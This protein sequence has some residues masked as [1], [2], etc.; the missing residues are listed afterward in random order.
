MEIEELQKAWEHMSHE[1]EHQK[2]LTDE[3]IMKMTKD[4]F[5]SKFRKLAT[6]ESIGAAICYG[7]SVLVLFNF[8]KLDTWYLMV[9]GIVTIAFLTILPTLVLGALREIQNVDI[10]NGT[11]KENLVTYS[12]AKNKLLKLQQIGIG[13]N[14]LVM[15]LVVPVTT[16]I[17]SNKNVFL[18]KMEPVQ[19][20]AIF[21]A[22]IFMFIISRWGYK[23]YLKITNSAAQIL[24]DFE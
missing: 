9:C 17:L 14:F 22:L 11:Y 10:S 21:V 8:N 5:K 12:K 15:F 6:Y 13:L 23:S 16:K 7:V 2:K 20:I 24:K 18:I 3:I 19:W 4:K 1:L